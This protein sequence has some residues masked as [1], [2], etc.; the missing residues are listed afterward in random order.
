MAR[1]SKQTPGLPVEAPK[2]TVMYY[3]TKGCFSFDI[4]AFELDE[5]DKPILNAEG[6]PK[7]AFFTDEKGNKTPIMD[8]YKFDRL[9]IKNEKTGKT[10]PT[11][12]IGRF[13]IDPEHPRAGDLVERLE[14]ARKH[15][16]NGILTEEEFKKYT[17]PLAFQHETEKNALKNEKDALQSENERLKKMLGEQGV[18]V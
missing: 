9:P 2:T 8:D 5:F 4:P 3:C 14:D 7:K 15:K 12:N 1:R 11:M 10:D 13:I 17:N 16:M 6:I 18:E